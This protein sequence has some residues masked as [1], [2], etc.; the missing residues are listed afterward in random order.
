MQFVDGLVQAFKQ[1]CFDLFQGKGKTAVLVLI[2][3]KGTKAALIP[4][5]IGIVEVLIVDVI[6][7]VL[8]V[9]FLA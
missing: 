4:A 1:I 5:N 3:R 9:R 6:R 8:V 7:L 2:P